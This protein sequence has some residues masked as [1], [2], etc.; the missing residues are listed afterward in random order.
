[1]SP[2]GRIF[3]VLNLILAALFRG[4]ASNTL[5]NSQA[6][7]EKY[8]GELSAHE[9]TKAST[10]KSISELRPELQQARGD[11][12]RFAGERDQ[13]DT[14]ISRLNADLA[15][16]KGENDDMRGNLATLANSYEQTQAH[17]KELVTQK[18]QADQARN[19]AETRA[20]ASERSEQQAKSALQLA[21]QTI[22][23]LENQVSDLEIAVAS[24]KKDIS[25]LE[26]QIAMLVDKTGVK[27]SE[28]IAQPAI[29]GAVLQ[30]LHDIPPGLLAINKGAN[31]GV[32]RGYTF[33]I[34]E[35]KQY[36]GRA[37]VENVR[38]DMSTCIILDTFPGQTV[39]QGDRA[40]TVL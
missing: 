36:K 2:I 17:N 38:P 23:S 1:M 20:G 8:E 29:D 3:I 24:G 11:A 12:S 37:R 40:S 31:D 16:A 22:A 27:L 6:F 10:A 30:V 7:K 26:T 14:T 25:G 39:Q 5:A 15:A 4:W 9:E 33:D 18:G 28:I 32:K 34:Y 35:G 13:R 19:D 21:Q